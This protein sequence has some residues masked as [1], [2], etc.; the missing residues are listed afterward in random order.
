[1]LSAE[2]ACEGFIAKEDLLEPD[3]GLSTSIYQDGGA[4]LASLD[5]SEGWEITRNTFKPYAACLLT[6]ALIDAARFV[7]EGIQQVIN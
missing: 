2:L 6:H 5:F 7:A 3:G 4:A 1:M